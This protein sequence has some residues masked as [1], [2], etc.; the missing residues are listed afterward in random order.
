M[1]DIATVRDWTMKYVA[2]H[3][4]KISVEVFDGLSFMLI[5]YM[6]ISV[7]FCSSTFWPSSRALP[8]LGDDR[9]VYWSEDRVL[10]S[11]PILVYIALSEERAF[12]VTPEDGFLLPNDATL[13][14]DNLWIPALVFSACAAK[15]GV[16]RLT[17]QIWYCC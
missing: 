8:H 12:T 1:G 9:R 11:V 4:L 5:G 13:V 14:T 17:S 16:R 15:E 3:I 6:M 7:L 10:G 2:S